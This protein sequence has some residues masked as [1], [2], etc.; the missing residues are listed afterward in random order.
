[1]PCSFYSPIFLVPRI[2]RSP[3]MAPEKRPFFRS[4]RARIYS[5]RKCTLFLLRLNFDENAE[6]TGRSRSFVPNRYRGMRFII[7][8]RPETIMAMTVEIK[9]FQF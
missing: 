5:V 7:F 4:H 8:A 9:I 2:P 3:G 6:N 1:M